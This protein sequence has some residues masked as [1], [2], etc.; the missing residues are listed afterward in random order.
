M[1][2]TNTGNGY[3]DVTDQT[4]TTAEGQSSETI[5]TVTGMNS[6]NYYRYLSEVRD[7]NGNLTSWSLSSFTNDSL[8]SQQFTLIEEGTTD[9]ANPFF[10]EQDSTTFD[11]FGNVLRS[12]TDVDFLGNSFST[13]VSN[14]YVIDA[15]GRVLSSISQTDS[16]GDGTVDAVTQTFFTYDKA[17]NVSVQDVKQF[18]GD[19]TFQTE[20]VSTFTYDRAGNVS[21]Q[22]TK[23]FGSY[24]AFQTETVSTF[25]HDRFGNQLSAES[26]TRNANGTLTAS[27]SDEEE[28]VSRGQAFDRPNAGQHFADQV[29]NRGR[30]LSEGR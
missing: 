13:V 6:T 27:S 1:T 24:S 21:V 30:A 29:R 26:T 28:Y 22:D 20:A 25:D 18:G 7:M 5:T 2:S 12:T 10:V 3:R 19:G 8:H 15:K 17:G 23:Q 9:E 16:G 11:S 14:T 4:T